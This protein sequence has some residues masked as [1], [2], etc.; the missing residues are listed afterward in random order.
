MS[1]APPLP[2]PTSTRLGTVW[3]L[4]QLRF[5]AVGRVTPVGYT[6]RKLLA[7][8]LVTVTLSTTALASARTWPTPVTG[9]VRD[10]PGA[11]GPAPFRLS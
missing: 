7:V 6:V 11:S 1:T 2:T 5:D 8:V 10:E 3:P 4:T 9:I